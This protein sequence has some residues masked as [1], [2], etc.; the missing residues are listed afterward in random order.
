[1]RIIDVISHIAIQAWHVTPAKQLEPHVE[2]RDVEM[3]ECCYKQDGHRDKRNK[4]LVPV[5]DITKLPILLALSSSFLSYKTTA[6]IYKI[7]SSW[8]IFMCIDDM[9]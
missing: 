2:M 4:Q 6:H 8:D 3:S 5:G 1:M 9:I 7:I